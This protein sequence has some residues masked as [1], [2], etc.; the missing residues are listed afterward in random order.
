VSHDQCA[1]AIACFSDGLLLVCT[2]ERCVALLDTKT[3]PPTTVAESPQLPFDVYGLAADAETGWLAACG[4]LRTNDNVNVSLLRLEE[5]G[6][7]RRLVVARS[8][9]LDP[10]R[11]RRRLR[12]QMNGVRF[13]WALQ[14]APAAAAAEGSSAEA[15]PL[16]RRRVLLLA[17]QD[18]HVYACALPAPGDAAQLVLI[19]SHR[20]PTAVNS[21]A[22][23]PDGRWLACVGDREE[24]FLTGGERGWLGAAV[25][26]C[27]LRF[28]PG[29][30]PQPFFHRP[31]GSQYVSWSDDSRRLAA[32]SDTLNAV[33]V[34]AVSA[35]ASAAPAPLARID[36][37]GAAVLA[38]TFTPSSGGAHILAFVEKER[39]LYAVDVDGVGAADGW[40]RPLSASL[41]GGYMRARGVQRIRL[42]SG[43]E[44]RITGLTLTPSC[45][46]ASV[47]GRLFAFRPLTAWSMAQHALFPARLREAVVLLLLANSRG[48]PSDESAG[49]TARA[50]N[51]RR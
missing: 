41:G 37:F 5:E 25:P 17:S 24:V 31:A 42:Q 15:A 2:R 40:R 29:P 28:L 11:P 30:H 48:Q 6:D 38:L 47:A 10:P 7:S 9:G 49:A 21:A 46:F 1:D 33:A 44:G 39:N 19:V 35:D 12:D 26:L 18:K 45:I 22:A 32:S 4:R 14:E 36:G 27:S 51:D 34:W 8:F 20:F 3:E 50:F 23:S 16:Q 13:A 43:A